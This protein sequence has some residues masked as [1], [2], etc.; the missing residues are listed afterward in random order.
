[1]S[2]APDIAGASALDDTALIERALSRDR[3]ALRVLVDRLTP[4]VQ[5]R[6]ARVLLRREGA[7]RGRRLRQEVEDFAQEV[8]V[9]LIAEDG[10]A[11]RRWSAERGMSLK[12]FVGLIAERQAI[13]ILRSGRRSPWTED[14]TF[15]DTL[16]HQAGAHAGHG[17]HV[18]ARDLLARVLD[19]I[20]V[21]LSP[22]GLQ[23]FELLMIQQKA[24]PEV[25]TTTGMTA[26]AVYAWRSRLAKLAR[27]IRTELS[28]S[29][30]PARTP[31]GGAR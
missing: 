26:D 6:V 17:A 13:S 20:R 29:Y 7:A 27:Q 15:S 9:S 3:A 21:R 10:K 23:L 18:D 4:V 16:S 28:E 24:I 1:M 31:V 19:Q 30:T 8:F 12:N 11:L 2:P 25:C 5:A 14:P 22:K